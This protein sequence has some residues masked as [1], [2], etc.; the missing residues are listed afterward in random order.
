MKDG[1]RFG[2]WERIGNVLRLLDERGKPMG[3][4][5]EFY[6]DYREEPHLAVANLLRQM[7]SRD[8]SRRDLEDL[9]EAI[10]AAWSRGDELSR[11]DTTTA[12]MQ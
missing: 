8:V 3:E 10:S 7:V 12:M 4:N 5:Y 11:F 1:E 9:A 2:N 6:L